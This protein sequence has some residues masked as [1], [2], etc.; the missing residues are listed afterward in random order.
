MA[1]KIKV[2]TCK[3][4]PVTSIVP[5]QWKEWFFA[6]LSS[7]APFSWGDNNLTMVDVERFARQ[8]EIVLEDNCAAPGA[9]REWLKMVRRLDPGA[10]RFATP[11]VYIDLES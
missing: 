4:V 6:A 2:L 5:V 11:K 10:V 9:V 3:Y 1:R 7:S 8:C